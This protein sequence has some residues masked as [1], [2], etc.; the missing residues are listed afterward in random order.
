MG[1]WISKQYLYNSSL[2]TN[3]F[4]VSASYFGCIA[5]DTLQFTMKLISFHLLQQTLILDALRFL[6]LLKTQ[7]TL[8][9]HHMLVA[10]GVLIIKFSITIPVIHMI[11]ITLFLLLATMSN[12]YSHVQ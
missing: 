11:L 9:L 1:K 7:L 5:Y 12:S 2:D 6:F 3:Y 8:L 10:L 4:N